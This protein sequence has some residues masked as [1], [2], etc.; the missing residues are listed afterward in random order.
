MVRT[1]LYIALYLADL[2][3]DFIGTTILNETKEKYTE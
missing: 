3:L 2:P 1:L